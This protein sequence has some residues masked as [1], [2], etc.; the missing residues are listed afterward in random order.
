[1]THQKGS[2]QTQPQPFVN[3]WKW[4]PLWWNFFFFPREIK[5]VFPCEITYIPLGLELS[6]LL[7]A[8]SSISYHHSLPSKYMPLKQSQ[9]TILSIPL[10]LLWSLH[11]LEEGIGPWPRV[12]LLIIFMQYLGKS[13]ID[14]DGPSVPWS[15]PF[16]A[17]SIPW[18]FFHFILIIRFHG[19][20][21]ILSIPLPLIKYT[22][23]SDY[24]F[25]F[26]SLVPLIIRLLFLKVIRTT[27]PLK[28]VLLYKLRYNEPS[29]ESSCCI[30][31]HFLDSFAPSYSTS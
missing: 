16:W 23:V 1:M 12:C 7:R 28:H 17:F 13:N 26:Y 15:L 11:L 6:S 29:S 20:P 25:L 4:G 5:S 30:Y 3:L 31:S 9:R 2:S 27:S 10:L 19:H 14:V 22:P 18:Y 21:Y 8:S 24:H